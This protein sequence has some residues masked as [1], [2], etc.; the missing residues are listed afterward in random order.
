MIEQ[1][2][3]KITINGNVKLKNHGLMFEKS[4]VMKRFFETRLL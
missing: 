1:K 4:I 2:C 3:K